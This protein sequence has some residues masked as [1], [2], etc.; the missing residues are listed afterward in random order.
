MVM[1]R[2]GYIK[3]CDRLGDTYRW[4]GENVATVEVE[5]Q[6]SKY[7]NSSETIVYGVEIP[8]EEGKTGM[9][10]FVKNDSLNLKDLSD[11]LKDHLPA[12]ARPLFIRLLSDI[13]YTGTFKIKKTTL[14]DEGFNL[15]K[16]KSDSIFYFDVKEQNYKQ[17]N[18][19]IYQNIMDRK[20]RF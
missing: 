19:N 18:E 5:N 11:Y 1:D 15:S 4:R 20:L 9:A 3:F 12:Y 8:G 2:F 7:L 14:A 16:I 6:I 10:A 17:M 13:E